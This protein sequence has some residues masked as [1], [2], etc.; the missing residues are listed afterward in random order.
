M[1]VRLQIVFD[2]IAQPPAAGDALGA[3]SAGIVQ[4]VTSIQALDQEFCAMIASGDTVQLAPG[5]FSL[6]MIAW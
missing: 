6:D 2:P 3:L 1:G 5:T 4:Y